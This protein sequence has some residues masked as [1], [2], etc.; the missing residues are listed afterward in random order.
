[1][2]LGSVDAERSELQFLSWILV[3]VSGERT[4]L[5]GLEGLWSQC[6]MLGLFGSKNARPGEMAPGTVAER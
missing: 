3:G 6:L 4:G 1:M 5:G 2:G